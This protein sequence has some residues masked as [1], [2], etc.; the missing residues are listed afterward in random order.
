MIL[1][2]LHELH[3]VEWHDDYKFGRKKVVALYTYLKGTAPA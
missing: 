1:Y 3:S 2:Q